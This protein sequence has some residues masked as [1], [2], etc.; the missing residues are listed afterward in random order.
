MIVLKHKGLSMLARIFWLLVPLFSATVLS[1]CPDPCVAG[2]NGCNENSDCAAGMHC[3]AH[4]G[5][6]NDCFLVKGTCQ[7]MQNC[8]TAA[9]CHSAEC[10]DELTH[11]CAPKGACTASCE[12]DTDCPPLEKCSSEYA[13]RQGRCRPA[14]NVDGVEF[15]CDP[16]SFCINGACSVFLGTPCDVEDGFAGLVKDCGRSMICMN[17]RVVSGCANLAN[18]ADQV[19]FSEPGPYGYCALRAPKYY[20]SCWDNI[21]GPVRCDSECPEGSC[22]SV[23]IENG[24]ADVDEYC[25]APAPK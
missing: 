8:D 2:G 13:G 16:G 14:C 5:H 21:D 3:L 4:F 19:R 6:V 11:L 17:Q 9:D 24:S 22:Y 1:A 23:T 25:S 10:C 15:A 7:P 12:Y 20:N 18:E